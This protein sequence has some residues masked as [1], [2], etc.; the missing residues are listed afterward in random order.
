MPVASFA[1]FGQSHKSTFDR[2][3]YKQSRKRKRHQDSVEH[4]DSFQSAPFDSVTSGTNR[5]TSDDAEPSSDEEDYQYPF[6]HAAPKTH[7]TAR[8]HLSDTK[9]SILTTSESLPYLVSSSGEE[10][11][12]ARSSP[13]SGL[14]QQHYNVLISILHRCL[15]EGDYTRASRAWGMLLRTET[16]GHPLDIR[17]QERWGIGAELLLRPNSNPDDVTTLQNLAKA[18]DY[19]E[20]LILQ[21]PYRKTAPDSTSS[22]TFYPVM[23]GVWIYSIQLRY[24]FATRSTPLRSRSPAD[25][26]LNDHNSSDSGDK[27]SGPTC[28]P[29]TP[30]D[31]VRLACET[32]VQEV[33]EVV[34][35]LGELLISPP[36]SDHAA[37]WRIQGML[38]VW[39]SHLM[40]HAAASPQRS[41]HVED[42]PVFS[43]ARQSSGAG[44]DAHAHGDAG[45]TESFDY[46]E[47]LNRGR[48]AFARVLNMG[49]K[50]DVS[51]LQ[52]VGLGHSTG[53]N[54]L[55]KYGDSG[56]E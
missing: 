56:D 49:E 29:N 47:A 38:F 4:S 39:I 1:S 53:S 37:L 16:H 7:A 50:V 27:P 33:K 43:S 12:L 55:R 40:D 48:E 25:S 54:H 52:A 15:L 35:R 28:A 11:P 2:Q 19:Y 42:E 3:S 44:A 36:F 32:A 30:T 18:K 5:I 20:R 17:Y 31:N 8:S 10:L 21:Y 51:L 14:R 26:Y 41:G 9:P 6:P 13:N 22:L 23:F 45:A 34:E 46:E 24:K